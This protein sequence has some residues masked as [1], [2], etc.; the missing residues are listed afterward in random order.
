MVCEEVENR[1]RFLGSLELKTV[2][3]AKFGSKLWGETEIV[4][5]V[6]GRK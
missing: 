3:G 2:G 1:V 6:G 4:D 5:E